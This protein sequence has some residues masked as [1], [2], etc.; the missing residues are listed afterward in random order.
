MITQAYIIKNEGSWIWAG[1]MLNLSISI[2][3]MIPF[4]MTKNGQGKEPTTGRYAESQ[5]SYVSIT[6]IGLLSW[7]SL[8]KWRNGDFSPSTIA[9]PG[10]TKRTSTG[11]VL[12]TILD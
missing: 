7:R 5:C 8:T 3:F 2:Q 1:I 12:I 10:P 11:N 4:W 9:L 6:G